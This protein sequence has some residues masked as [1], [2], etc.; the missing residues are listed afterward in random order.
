MPTAIDALSSYNSNGPSSAAAHGSPTLGKNEFLKLLTTQLANQDPL[1]PADN[2]AFIAQLAQFASVEQQEA[3]NSR[4]D[5]LIVAQAANNQ[6]SVANLVGKEIIYKTDSVAV[7]ADRIGA[8]QGELAADAK[9][10]SA[11]IT[12]ENGKILRTLT[13]RDVPSGT[14]DFG[15]DGM[16]DHGVKVP[17]GTYKV[18]LTAGDA[19]DKTITFDSAGH[20]RA[21]GVTF[22]AGYPELI[23]NGVRVKLSDVIQIA[24]AMP[25][26]NRRRLN[27]RNLTT[28]SLLTA[29]TTG[30][31]GMQTNSTELSVIGDNIANANTIGFKAGRAAFEDQL[32]PAADRRAGRRTDGPGLAARGHSAHRHP[33]RDEPPPDW[34]PT[35][36]SMAAATSWSRAPRSGIQ[37]Q[38]YSR[39]GQFV[40]N[41]DG[42]LTSLD[43]LRVQGYPTSGSGQARG[44]LGDLQVG[45]ATAAAVPTANITLRANL[46]ASSPIQVFDP[47]NPTH[48]LRLLVDHHHLRLAGQGAHRR[49]VLEPHS[50]PAPGNSTP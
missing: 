22:E 15:W 21:T 5:A 8:I 50:R 14:V 24:E 1:A 48:H 9:Q 4:L 12:D 11:I 36:R 45:N 10:V 41:D 43:G 2:Q 30:T 13:L 31:A 25:Q 42:F 18:K 28:M 6:T 34:P 44:G 35:S 46:N 26:P 40:I 38:F 16:D 7:T 37:G 20:A 39:A 47:A 23:L 33:G 32:L 3:A 49:R 29:L 17:P 27:T 19:Q